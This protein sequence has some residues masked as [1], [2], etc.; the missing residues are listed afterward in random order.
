MPMVGRWIAGGRIRQSD[1]RKSIARLR[2][3]DR[4][5]A[6]P[7][8]TARENELDCETWSARD[9]A[10]GREIALCLHDDAHMMKGRWIA[11]AFDWARKLPRR[12]GR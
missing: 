3:V 7:S 6:E 12:S 10:S 8:R 5:P 4:C 9:C 2:A 1:V 11:E